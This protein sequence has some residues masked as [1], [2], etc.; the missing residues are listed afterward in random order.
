MPLTIVQKRSVKSEFESGGTQY[1][2]GTLS[3]NAPTTVKLDPVIFATTGNYILFDFSGGGSFAGDQSM[4]DQVSVDATDLGLSGV[5]EPGYGPNV[6]QLDTDN[7]RIIL[8]LQS[9]PTNGKQFVEGDLTF[10]EPTTMILSEEL[11]KTR[12]TYELFE[13]NG[14]ITGESF[15]SVTSLAGFSG[16][17]YVNAERTKVLVTLA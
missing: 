17:P 4:L 8:K 14:A 13:V 16:T 7:D 12:G 2:M 1:V 9:N 6:L 5:A 15:L 10:T 3:F 11:Y